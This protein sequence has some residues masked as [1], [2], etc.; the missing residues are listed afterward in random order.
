MYLE[1]GVEMEKMILVRNFSR[2]FEV[3]TS[4]SIIAKR[5]RLVSTT[6]YYSSDLNNKLKLLW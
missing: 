5:W 2:Y 6:K 3:L 4:I 1:L